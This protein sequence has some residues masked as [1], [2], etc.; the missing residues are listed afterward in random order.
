MVV[1]RNTQRARE[2]R[3]CLTD[4]EVKFWLVV[5]DRRLGGFK[6]KRQVAIGPY[7]GDFACKS[8]RLVVELDGSQHA[9]HVTYDEVR[10]RFMEASGYRVLRFWNHDV[11]ANIEGVIGVIESSLLET[12]PHPNL[13]P[14][15]GEGDKQ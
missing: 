13:P 7:I 5:R 3:Q 1:Y 2:L 14:Q 6:F 12:R 11:L 15:T 9:G 10:T 4:A 8:H